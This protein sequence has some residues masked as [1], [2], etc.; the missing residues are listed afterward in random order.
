MIPGQI[1]AW[2]NDTGEP[3][4]AVAHEVEQQPSGQ[5][6]P[7]AAR[8]GSF[9][10][11]VCTEDLRLLEETVEDQEVGEEAGDVHRLES[12]SAA[13]A[14][15]FAAVQKALIENREHALAVLARCAEE[16][17]Q[18]DRAL[19]KGRALRAAKLSQQ[20][21]AQGGSADA[22]PA[23]PPPQAEET[24]LVAWQAPGVPVSEAPE[25]PSERA[26]SMQV[27]GHERAPS[28][29][30]PGHERAPSLQLPGD[31]QEGGAYKSESPS[32]APSDGAAAAAAEGA[33]EDGEVTVKVRARRPSVASCHSQASMQSC[34]HNWELL[35]TW[36]RKAPNKRSKK[37]SEKIRKLTRSCS[38]ESLGSLESCDAGFDDQRWCCIPVLDPNSAK[39]ITWDIVSIIFVIYDM[40]MV[41]LQLLD[42]PQDPFIETM[43]WTT[44]LFWTLDIFL[45]FVTGVLKPDGSVEMQLAKIAKSYICSWF[46][47]DLFIVSMDWVE[48]AIHSGDIGGYSRAGQATRAFRIIRLVRLVR[49][50]RLRNVSTLMQGRLKS[51]QLLIVAGIINVMLVIMGLG[52]VIACLWHAIAAQDRPD[53]WLNEHGFADASLSMRY[54]TAL[55]W[56]LLQFAGGTDE[57]VPQ[58]TGER[59]YAIGVFLLAFVMASVFV[60]RLTSSMTQ[61]HMLSRQDAEKFHMLKQYLQKN[62]ISTILTVRVMH[63]AQHALA[64]TQRF[65][66]ESRVELLSLISEPLRVELHFELYSPVLEVHPFFRCFIDACPQVMK[67]VCH[68]AM[69]Q[70]LVSTGDVI[71]MLGEVPSPPRMFVIC[72]GELSY[73]PV[74]GAVTTVEA[75]QWLSEATLW[76]SWTHQ[77]ML[78]AASDCRLCLLNAN[79]FQELAENFD[80]DFDL[81]S[82][83]RAFVHSMNTGLIDASDLPFDTDAI[84]LLEAIAA[85]GANSNGGGTSKSLESSTHRWNRQGTAGS[86]G[87]SHSGS[88]VGQ[89][90]VTGGTPKTSVLMVS[91][92][93]S[94]SENGRPWW[95]R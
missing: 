24:R 29:Q 45:S 89:D 64:E 92:C 21:G 35:P 60:G 37:R 36:A 51:E 12:A 71:F 47:V 65:M 40:V 88:D 94:P 27:P 30:A 73:Y 43:M 31:A 81:R 80:Y 91:P 13:V 86:V 10:E 48:A 75:G 85:L 46:L 17:Q 19:L 54:T 22:G 15:S 38:F 49:L 53:T 93:T 67:R 79:K 50:V 63:N 11:S 69:S 62:Q 44:R 55:H 56:S 74:N 52:H 3:R 32:P 5:V 82:Y 66:E 4:K 77:G 84:D 95:Q 20:N 39:R 9:A 87:S 18:K 7:Q 42:L 8:A 34:V 83:A 16:V 68:Q 33:E 59:V 23:L 14:A 28:M 57:I 1:A 72:S 2:E 58:N 26:P 90:S 25:A 41:P 6:G 78:K 61:L 70:L 76:T